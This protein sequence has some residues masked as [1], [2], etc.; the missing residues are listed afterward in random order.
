MQFDFRRG[1]K[2]CSVC[3][4]RFAPGQKFVSALMEQDDGQTT[5][6]DF[7][8]D[9]WE[10]QQPECIGFWNQQTADLTTGKIYWAPRDVLISYFEYLLDQKKLETAWVMSLLMI[11]KKI[12]SMTSTFEEESGSGRVLTDRMSSKVYEV[13]DVEI[14]PDK[15]QQ[16]QTELSENLFSNQPAAD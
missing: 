9:D 7:C 13:P 6:A 14:A 1:G 4:S 15:I 5:R 3:E 11:Q 10:S 8:M 12:L 2:K 16:I